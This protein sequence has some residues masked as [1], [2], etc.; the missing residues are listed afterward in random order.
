MS[1]IPYLTHPCP[2][3]I[4]RELCV[5]CAE[6]DLIVQQLVNWTVDHI[7]PEYWEDFLTVPDMY[8]TDDGKMYQQMVA[9]DRIIAEGDVEEIEAMTELVTNGDVKARTR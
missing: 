7:L 4:G 6:I 3:S 9:I 2:H 5:A 8:R 1:S